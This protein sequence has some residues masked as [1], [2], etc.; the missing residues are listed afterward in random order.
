MFFQYYLNLTFFY[1]GDSVSTY[2]PY[3]LKRN[4]GAFAIFGWGV[5]VPLGAIAARYLRHKDPLWYYLHVLVQ[6]LG[7]I[8][9]FAGVVSGIA[10]YNR[11]Y[12]NFTTHR[13]LGISVLALGSLQVSMIMQ[14]ILP[15]W[16]LMPI[17]WFISV[18]SEAIG[19]TTCYRLLHF[20]FILIRILRCGNVGTSTTIG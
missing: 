17:I 8:I 18:M 14:L 15:S 7:Y 9:G 10:L 5:L 6:F 1:A 12:S 3:Q 4:H 19:C 11:T 13:S 20:S 16:L 2:Y